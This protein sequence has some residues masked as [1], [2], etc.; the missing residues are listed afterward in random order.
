MKNQRLATLVKF[1]VTHPS[2]ESQDILSKIK[3]ERLYLTPHTTKNEAQW[4]S[5]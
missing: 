4:L 3:K 1:L 2:G 5:P